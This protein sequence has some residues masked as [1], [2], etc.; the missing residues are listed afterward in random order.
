MEM[1]AEENG[2]EID[3]YK[4]NYSCAVLWKLL[5]LGIMIM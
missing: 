1:D 4:E 3:E 5:K 2:K